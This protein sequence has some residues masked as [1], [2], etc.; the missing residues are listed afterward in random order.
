MERLSHKQ[1]LVLS[2]HNISAHNV[3]YVKLRIGFPQAA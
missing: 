2:P 3:Y 1:T